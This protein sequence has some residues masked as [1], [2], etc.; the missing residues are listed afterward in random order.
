MANV[1]KHSFGFQMQ[2]SPPLPHAAYDLNTYMNHV[3]T[4][5]ILDFFLDL[6]YNISTELREGIRCLTY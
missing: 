6:W 5:K 1:L 3:N 4:A 2:P